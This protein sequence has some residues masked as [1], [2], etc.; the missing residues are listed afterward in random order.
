MEGT[1]PASAGGDLPRAA[2]PELLLAGAV[3]LERFVDRVAGNGDG[4]ADARALHSS[5]ENLI[6]GVGG[7]GHGTG[8]GGA[9]QFDFAGVLILIGAA[10]DFHD[11]ILK[12]G[13]GDALEHRGRVVGVGDEQHVVGL[14]ETERAEFVREIRRL[15]VPADVD[16]VAVDAE[17]RFARLDQIGG[18]D[19]VLK[20]DQP[21]IP[22]GRGD[23]D[24]KSSGTVFNAAPRH[25]QE[26]FQHRATV[27][28]FGEVGAVA[29]TRPP[30]AAVEVVDQIAHCMNSTG[31]RL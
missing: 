2:H 4:P 26:V 7:D 24:M 18:F 10:P 23:G 13:F 5:F 19:V 25:R 31:G 1:D 22:G 14:G 29:Q 6:R 15:H 8:R 9:G 30:F 20:C 17:I 12:F 3:P 21:D 28:V 27:A 16:A 11:L